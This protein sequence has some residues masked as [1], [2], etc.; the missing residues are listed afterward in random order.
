MMKMFRKA[1]I[2]LSSRWQLSEEL[3]DANDADLQ[4]TE[5]NDA[6]AQKIA[7][8]H[9]LLNSSS[10]SRYFK[11][12]LQTNPGDGSKFIIGKFMGVDGQHGVPEM[13]LT[14]HATPGAGY[15]GMLMKTVKPG[16]VEFLQYSTKAAEQIPD[17]VLDYLAL[18]MNRMELQ[19]LLGS[20]R[21]RQSSWSASRKRLLKI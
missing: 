13:S 4:L 12:Y 19:S 18:L 15:D 8:A 6:R 10:L 17:K 20:D 9:D 5:T 3:H 14:V 7:V 1:L 21:P 2:N 11:F 16:R